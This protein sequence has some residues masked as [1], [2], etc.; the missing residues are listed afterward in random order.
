MRPRKK[1][2]VLLVVGIFLSAV[3]AVW[4]AWPKKEVLPAETLGELLEQTECLAALEPFLDKAGI[5][6][7]TS[8]SEPPVQTTRLG[9]ELIESLN[10]EEYGLKFSK[11]G[12]L[13]RAV[14][15]PSSYENAPE[16]PEGLLTE[17]EF[18]KQIDEFLFLD[19]WGDAED[20]TYE[21]RV[22]PRSDLAE[23]YEPTSFDAMAQRSY[24][25]FLC[26]SGVSF[27]VD[28]RTGRM[29]EIANLPFKKPESLEVNISKEEALGIATAFASK[30]Q[31]PTNSYEVQQLITH[32]SD[33]WSITKT[34]LASFSP[35]TKL[36][37]VIDFEP[38]ARDYAIVVVDCATGKIVGGDLR[39]MPR[40][41]DD[42]LN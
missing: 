28:R 33:F 16:R 34:V 12:V 32:T 3:V 35:D 4:N 36:C 18:R 5:A 30:K 10:Y 24:Q 39:Q 37:W 21:I 27:S 6:K 20:I 14:L 15:M 9:V 1:Q 22:H 2:L 38:R 41:P 11:K 25:G 19:I 17:E 40:P 42:N 8:L 23:E 29:T 7:D 31:I 26:A 13:Y